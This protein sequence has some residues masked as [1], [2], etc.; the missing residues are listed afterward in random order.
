MPSTSPGHISATSR[1]RSP[2]ALVCRVRRAARSFAVSGIS[3]SAA[4]T[5]AFRASRSSRRKDSRSRTRASLVQ[6]RSRRIS[7]NPGSSPALGGTRRCLLAAR[8]VSCSA[9][10]RSSLGLSNFG[11][12]EAHQYRPLTRPIILGLGDAPCRACSLRGYLTPY[13]A[14]RCTCGYRSRALEHAQRLGI[15][16]WNPCSAL[17]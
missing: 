2:R 3:V 4:D 1:R 16:T 8:A 5:A 6:L 14:G 11:I 17:P 12:G 15:G 13:S 9:G 10:L 7:S